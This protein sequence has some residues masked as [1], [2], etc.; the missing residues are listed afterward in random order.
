MIYAQELCVWI[1]NNWRSA[2]TIHTEPTSRKTNRLN[3]VWRDRRTEVSEEIKRLYA[4][5]GGEGEPSSDKVFQLRS[6]AA[7]NVY[8]GLSEDEKAMVMKEVE[9][10]GQEANPPDVQKRSVRCLLAN[11]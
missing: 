2:K 6:T 9:N 5:A 8:I 7:R 4:E 1:R 11:L 10:S 3:I